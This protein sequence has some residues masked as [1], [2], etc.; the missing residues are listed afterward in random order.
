MH[1]NMLYDCRVARLLSPLVGLPLTCNIFNSCMML[2]ECSKYAALCSN[3]TDVQPL[4]LDA[5]MLF[6]RSVWYEESSHVEAKY[7]VTGGLPERAWMG[8]F[9]ASDFTFNLWPLV[10]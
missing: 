3:V 9:Q 8:E 7:P 10:N 4:D 1:V 2:G 6:K 5:C